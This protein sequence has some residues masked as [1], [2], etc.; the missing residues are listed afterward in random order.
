M[1]KLA[2]SAR[3]SVFITLLLLEDSAVRLSLFRKG[4]IID[5]IELLVGLNYSSVYLRLL[6]NKLLLLSRV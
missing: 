2:F 1:D 6:P 4:L 5:I 3:F